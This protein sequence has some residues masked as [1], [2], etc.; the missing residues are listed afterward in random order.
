MELRRR[1]QFLDLRN[2]GFSGGTIADYVRLGPAV[3]PRY[4]PVAVVIQLSPGDFGAETF[5]ADHVNCFEKKSDGSLRLVHRDLGVGSPSLGAR[6]KHAVALVNYSE[7]RFLRIAERRTHAAAALAAE[8]DA[9]PTQ[10]LQWDTPASSGAS[11]ASPCPKLQLALHRSVH[12]GVLAAVAHLVVEMAA[13]PISTYRSVATGRGRRTHIDL[14]LTMFLGGLWHGAS[15]NFVLW[16]DS[17]E[18]T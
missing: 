6:V 1:E 17:T 9:T 8:G 7:L 3:M 15:W 11:W 2:L 16:G 14:L 12:H 18:L 13:G 5:D 10:V 4:G